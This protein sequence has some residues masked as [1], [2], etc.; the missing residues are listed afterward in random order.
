[1]NGLIKKM[2]IVMF[3]SF[4]A[5]HTAQAVTWS[6]VGDTTFQA[7]K[8]T[9]RAAYCLAKGGVSLISRCLPQDITGKAAAGGFS[10]GAAAVYMRCPKIAATGFIV[11]ACAG[12]LN[13]LYRDKRGSNTEILGKITPGGPREIVTTPESEIEYLKRILSDKDEPNLT[14]VYLGR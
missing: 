2:F 10:V 12:Y 6:Q 1:M 8:L 13:Y 7:A 14:G 4:S 9:A 11:G 5:S 3:I